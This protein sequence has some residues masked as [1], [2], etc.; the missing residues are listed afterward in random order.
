MNHGTGYD[1]QVFL[2][3][4]DLSREGREAIVR[5]RG[6]GRARLFMGALLLLAAV[7]TWGTVFMMSS[8][9]DSVVKGT[10]HV[11]TLIVTFKRNGAVGT[12][13]LCALAAWLLFPPRPK[14]P[15]RDWALV[16]LLAFLSG[17]SIYTLIW[18]KPPAAATLDADENLANGDMNMDWNGA[19]ADMEAMDTNAAALD[20][21]QLAVDR[22]RAD[23]AAKA[24]IQA[25]E[26]EVQATEPEASDNQSA[27]PDA[28]ADPLNEPDEPMNNESDANEE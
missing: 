6:I 16:A 20:S 23:A 17:T 14:W 7:M 9:G 22:A 10:E 21:S 5:N 28:D 1:R 2:R 3:W 15:A 25:S 19:G 24:K 18:L 13:I 26:D 11:R 8:Q 12:L 27:D 4:K